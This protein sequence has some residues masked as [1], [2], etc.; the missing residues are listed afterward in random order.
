MG[1][2]LLLRTLDNLR[3]VNPGFEVKNLLVFAVDPSLLNYSLSKTALLYQSLEQRLSALPGVQSA[4]YSSGAL[5]TGGEWDHSVTIENHANQNID[6]QILAT[7]P[8]F[9]NAMKIPLLTGRLFTPVDYQTPA[10]NINQA[11]KSSATTNKRVLPVLV[12]QA[13]AERYFPQGQAIGKWIK[14][15][16]D[17]HTHNSFEG[18]ATSKN[19]EIVGIVR[20]TLYQS[21]E[22]SVE[23]IVFIPVTPYGAYFEVR[24]YNDPHSLIA[25][26]RNAAHE[27]DSNIPLVNMETQ[28]ESISDMFSQQRLIARL[29]G[30][31]G[32]VAL[33]LACL[34]LYGL[35]SYEVARR[36]REIGIRMALGSS[37]P[38]IL[39][40][41]LREGIILTIIGLALGSVLALVFSRYLASLL[42]GVKPTDPVTLSTVVLLLILVSLFSC[43]IPAQRA[44]QVDPMVAIRA[45]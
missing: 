16:G 31:L 19:W 43:L 27:V 34:G 25:A 4:T 11:T 29:T 40:M 15:G 14:E 26:V 1:S 30:F 45:E 10:I 37:R 5:L 21:L 38:A 17:S 9:F 3:K 18:D 13:F 24:T 8:D 36:T 6:M 23:P 22:S 35:L 20:N 32:F 39:K 44:M 7:G 41:I 2:G 42:Y 33:L 28:T 12:N